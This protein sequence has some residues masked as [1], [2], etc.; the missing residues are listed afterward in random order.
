MADPASNTSSIPQQCPNCDAE[1]EV[2]FLHGGED[3]VQWSRVNRNEVIEF[4]KDVL[5]LQ[6]R[7]WTRSFRLSGA[8]DPEP[9]K[10]GRCVNCNLVIF[11]YEEALDWKAFKKK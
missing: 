11:A 5:Y 2:G 7:L 8:E 1:M 9:L 3:V 10:A 6:R 4:T